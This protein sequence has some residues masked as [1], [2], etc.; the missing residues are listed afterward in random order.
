ME[1]L[2]KKRAAFGNWQIM[3]A[4]NFFWG[5][6]AYVIVVIFGI[7]L[8]F[9]I[10]LFLFQD[11]LLYH[12]DKTTPD[13]VKSGLPE[14]QEVMTITEDG[15]KLRSWYTEGK[16]E[17][18]PIIVFFHGNAGNIGSRSE[19]VRLFL[20]SGFGILLVGYRGY[21]GN[22]GN[23]SEEGFYMDAR[24]SL[25]RLQ[26]MNK[27]MKPIVLY[28]ES[29]GTAVATRMAQE[30]ASSGTPIAALI[31]EAPFN[32][33]LA[34]ASYHYPF[35]PVKWLLND[36]FDQ[37]AHIARI[38]A[39]LLI[40]HGNL[41]KTVPIS[42][43]KELFEKALMPKKSK[44]YKEAGHNNLYNFGAGELCIDFIKEVVPLKF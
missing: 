10:S 5:G 31:L 17:K 21:G 41:D 15:H 35:V 23:P 30:F 13:P 6:M 20:D 19:K 1:Q 34:A 12:P 36:H 9:L 16:A 2:V 32:S 18:N 37:S 29:L 8:V 43:G 14:M 40:L 25:S 33:V 28:G 24:A 4:I 3:R 11:N 27:E 42:L 26:N 44:W 22:P 38:L 7:Y 39:P